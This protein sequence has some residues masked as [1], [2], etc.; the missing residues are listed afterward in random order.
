[1]RVEFYLPELAERE[2]T[3]RAD[4]ASIA[5]G[6]QGHWQ[7]SL[8]AVPKRVV[9]FASRADH[10][11]LE[12]LWRIQSG[13]LFAN[14]QM[15]VSN[16]TVLEPLAA[17]YNVPFH[18]VPKHA[19]NRA[20]AELEELRLIGDKAD[21]IVLARYMQII[22]PAFLNLYRNRIINI[23]HSFLPAFVGADP[24][25]GA[26]DRGVK[27]IGATAHYVTE[28][29]DAGPIIEQDVLRVTHAQSVDDLRRI[30]RFVER[31]VLARAVESHLD[32]RVIVHENKT[33]VFQ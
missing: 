2:Q 19:G 20:D 1:M 32:D 11:L 5:S 8:A 4:F 17:R 24:Y 12:L 22:S 30:G 3:F 13:D 10:A 15:V 6:F 33:I 9:L 23:H 25:K 26:F 7:L 21:L 14:V 31:S 28:E 27:L 29:L 18:H 16:H